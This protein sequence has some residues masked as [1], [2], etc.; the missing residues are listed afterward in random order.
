MDAEEVVQEEAQG[1]DEGEAGAESS[2]TPPD[3]HPEKPKLGRLGINSWPG[4]QNWGLNHT[5][6]EK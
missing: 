5:E 6:T 1:G 2:Q 4:Q 3:V